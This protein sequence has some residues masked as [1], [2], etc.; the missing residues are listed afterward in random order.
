MSEHGAFM[1]SLEVAPGIFQIQVPIPYPLKY[2][3]CYLIKG[4]GTAL[5]DCAL[6]TQDTKGSLALPAGKEVLRAALLEHSLRF[7]DLDQ[8]VITHHHPDHYGLAGILEAEGAKV[9]ML[10]VELE[11]GHRFWTE[12][13]EHNAAG[14][15]HLQLHGVPEETLAGL[16]GAMAKT[17]SCVHPAKAPVTLKDGDYTELAGMKF[18]VVWT[19]GHADGHAVFWREHDSVL[20][21]GDQ[22]LE[23]VTP[24][25]GLWAYSRPN[26]LED[27]LASFK[28]VSALD[29]SLALTGHYRPIENIRERIREIEAHHQER[30]ASLEGLLKAGPATC[31]QLSLKL[32]PGNYNLAQRRFA[33][34]ETLAHLEYLVH[35]SQAKKEFAKNKF[36]Y[37]L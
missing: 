11:H 2:V 21:A 8:L 5:V 26:P 28:K 15:A 14:L 27:Y 24:N 3:N 7:S 25:I 29:A 35:Q 12:P 13:E 1:A 4:E 10:D 37:S 20:L 22:L 17:R 32:F 18:K 30:L 31:W 19:P 9:S 6:D 34:A 33:W 16:A 23:R 36:L